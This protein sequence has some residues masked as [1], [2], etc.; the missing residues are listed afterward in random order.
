MFLTHLH[1]DH[2][3]DLANLFV[4]SWPPDPIDVFGPGPAGLPIPMFPPD[5]DRP[6]VY[7]DEPT[8]GTRAALDHL[9]RAFAYNTNLRIADEGRIDVTQSARVHELGVR[10][11]GYVPDI[12]LGVRADAS[13]ELAAAPP[14]E[15]V[16]IY[17]EDDHGVQ[18]SAILV[19]HAPVFPAFGF[20][21]DTPGGSV[22]FSGDTGA[23]A[24]VTTLAMG[25]SVL[26]HEVIDVELLTERLTRLPNYEAVRNHLAS[27]HTAPEEVGAIADAGR[28][29]DARAVAPRAGRQRADRGRVGGAGPADDT[30]PTCSAASTSTSCALSR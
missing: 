2:I 4:G 14:M 29:R 12:D 19:Q 16:V 24:N 23:C 21:F 30:R 25:A 15:P 17:P 9:F 7:P 13:S 18:V 22:V 10:R 28:R 3:M 8:P 20:R 5:A 27:S 1:A 11:D 6:L 26:V